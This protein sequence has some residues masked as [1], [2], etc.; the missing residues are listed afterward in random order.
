[1]T[2][3]RLQ[4]AME[5]AQNCM[6]EI[7]T[8]FKPGAK[9]T[10]LVRRPGNNN[11]DFCMSSD[12]LEEVMAMVCRRKDAA[13]PPEGET[14]PITTE[15]PMGEREAARQEAVKLIERAGLE[16]EE[17]YDLLVDDITDT[18]LRFVAATP[19]PH[20]AGSVT[21]P[22]NSVKPLDPE[23]EAYEI[24]K[25]DGYS[26]AVQQIDQLTGGDG[27]Y[28]Y[29]LGDE[30]S[31]RHTPG[32]AEMIQRIVDRFETL[33]LLEEATRT[34]SDQP[35]D[36]PA[37]APRVTDEMIRVALAAFQSGDMD[38]SSQDE[39]LMR[40]ALEEALSASPTPAPHVA[41]LT[42]SQREA[43]AKALFWELE[44]HDRCPPEAR[45]AI[46]RHSTVRLIMQRLEEANP[47]SP[48]AHVTGE[49]ADAWAEKWRHTVQTM[50][51]MLAVNGN[52][53]PEEILSGLQE[54]L[55]EPPLDIERRMKETLFA[56]LDTGRKR[57]QY[58]GVLTTG[59]KAWITFDIRE[60]TPAPTARLLGTYEEILRV[61]CGHLELPQSESGPA[62][63]V[64][65]Y[66]R[67]LEALDEYSRKADAELAENKRLRFKAE[68]EVIQLCKALSDMLPPKLTWKER[69][70]DGFL[71]HHQVAA[72]NAARAALA[73]PAP[74]PRAMGSET[75]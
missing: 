11:A 57:I 26:E 10:L 62:D 28:R 48:T 56:A 9:I 23:D 72:I 40:F 16:M 52:G 45:D 33:S 59:G 1:M 29:C 17:E 4:R 71:V 44:N 60:D 13:S 20:V 22:D 53:S 64:T 54:K 7:L 32:P 68:A 38:W 34:G 6:D 39:E 30:G 36:A 66:D 27:E 37:P 19:A 74:A 51:V 61:V 70:A 31:A 55:N 15:N 50:C 49:E 35:D 14:S 58:G 25:R 21:N 69:D 42:A 47:S 3:E 2:D 12:N 43:F 5:C 8:H 65:L 67:A 75:E 63:D 46:R 73:A 24:G 18:M 41:A